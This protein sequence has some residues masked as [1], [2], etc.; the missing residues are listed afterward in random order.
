M[1][2]SLARRYP[3][4]CKVWEH[5]PLFSPRDVQIQLEHCDGLS[6]TSLHVVCLC[7]GT[8]PCKSVQRSKL[9]GI[10][11]CCAGS[12]A[13]WG[14]IQ[15]HQP[16]AVRGSGADHSGAP[17]ACVGPGPQRHSHPHGILGNAL[18]HH[19]HPRA[20]PLSVKLA[21]SW[22]LKYGTA[23]GSAIRSYGVGHCTMCRYSAD[24]S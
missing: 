11:P 16:S 24:Q 2:A 18:C 10:S 17:G 1:G 22:C 12:L 15:H 6:T 14:P 21:P 23:G 5:S 3:P 4:C 9:R 7:S 8:L 19:C 13:E 20:V